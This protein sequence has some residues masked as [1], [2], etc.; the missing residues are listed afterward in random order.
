MF[1]FGLYFSN[2]LIRHEI[3]RHSSSRGRANVNRLRLFEDTPN[4][5]GSLLHGLQVAHGTLRYALFFE[6]RGAP[7][8]SALRISSYLLLWIN[9]QREGR[10]ILESEPSLGTFHQPDGGFAHMHRMAVQQD[11]HRTATLNHESLVKA[12]KPRRVELV[13]KFL[14][15]I[16]TAATDHANGLERVAPALVFYHR[17][18]SSDSLCEPH[19]SIGTIAGF[20]HKQD[21]GTRRG[22]Q[23]T[24]RI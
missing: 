20:L 12:R 15:I 2:M 1:I 5:Q 23:W 4:Q 16:D 11:D 6:R 24:Y 14:P 18:P 13:P 3:G 22:N 7:R 8:P 9:F 21:L 17:R 19:L 10:R